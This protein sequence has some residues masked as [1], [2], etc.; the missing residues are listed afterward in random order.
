VAVRPDGAVLL[1]GFTGSPASF[2]GVVEA[3]PATVRVLRP[4]LLGHGPSGSGAGSFEGEVDRLAAQVGE[5]GLRRPVLCGYSLGGRLALALLAR[6]PSLFA[7]AVI[8]AGH[9]GLTDPTERASRIEGDERWATLLEQEGIAAFVDAWERQSLFATQAEL[10]EAVQKRQREMRLAH[11]P[12]GLARALRVLGL[13]R[14][15]DLRGGLRKVTVP[16]T[17]VVGEADSKFRALAR[18]LADGVFG[19]AEVRLVPGSG[20]NVV[21][22]APRAV[23][24]A[25]AGEP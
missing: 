10:P 4:T 17:L 19:G 25:I 21:L 12:S 20:H 2:D 5:S 11:D 6:H 3:L 1:H 14:M 16:V 9:S 18:S 24:R 23:A 13:G 8:V 7:R 22:E 15:P